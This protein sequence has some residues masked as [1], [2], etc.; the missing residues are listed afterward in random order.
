[1]G[2]LRYTENQ[3][4][5]HFL[6]YY[7]FSSGS[8]YTKNT[9]VLRDIACNFLEYYSFSWVGQNTQKIKPYVIPL[10]IIPFYLS[11]NILKFTGHVLE[12]CF[13]SQWAKIH[14]QSHAIPLS[15][16]SLKRSS[17]RKILP[18]LKYA[19]QSVLYTFYSLCKKHS[20]SKA[21]I[22]SSFTPMSPGFCV[23][24]ICKAGKTHPSSHLILTPLTTY[25]SFPLPIVKNSR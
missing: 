9:S 6:E 11:Q 23:I 14:N 5:C 20:I 7:F 1:M 25:L 3:T 8:K 12:Y 4:T 18:N 22:K 10:S 24:H 13:F 19:T 17:Y 21:V 2:Q 16:I 15:I